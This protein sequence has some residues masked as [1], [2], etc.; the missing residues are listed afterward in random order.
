[1]PLQSGDD[2]VL[3]AMNRWYDTETYLRACEEIRAA[4]DRPAFTA[5]VIVGFPGEDD[6][7]FERTL[8]TVRAAGFARMHVF[9]FSARPSTPAYE[10]KGAPKPE[11][12]RERRDDVLLVE[13][14][15]GGCGSAVYRRIR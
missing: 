13:H 5:D 6:A 8:E 11:V 10:L 1:M 14:H 2:G 15:H 7:A 9:P 12:V 4:L 3:K